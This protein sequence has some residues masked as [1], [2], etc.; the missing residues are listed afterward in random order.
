MCV[1]GMERDDISLAYK[2]ESELQGPSGKFVNF[3]EIKMTRA[4]PPL[5]FRCNVSIQ[6]LALQSDS[7]L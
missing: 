3:T 7:T 1:R 4:T 5:F 2:K 6:V